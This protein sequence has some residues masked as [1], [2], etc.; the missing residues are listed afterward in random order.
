MYEVE[1]LFIIRTC[2]IC[3]LYGL[4]DQGKQILKLPIHPAYQRVW[5][6]YRKKVCYSFKS[7]FFCMQNKS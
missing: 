6:I 7:A 3:H 2:T 4:T 1:N 5:Y